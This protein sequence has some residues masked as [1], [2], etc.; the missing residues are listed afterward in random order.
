MGLKIVGKKKPG[1]YDALA[2]RMNRGKTAQDKVEKQGERRITRTGFSE[3][4][5]KSE[6]RIP[7]VKPYRGGSRG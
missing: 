5:K 1:P 7:K 4:I 3:E 2:D 6:G